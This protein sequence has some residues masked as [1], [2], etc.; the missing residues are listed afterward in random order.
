MARLVGEQS[1]PRDGIKVFASQLHTHL[2][3][4]RIYTKHYRNG[5]EL[6]ELN[7]DNHFSPHYQEIR[8]LARPVHVLPVSSAHLRTCLSQS[9]HLCRDYH[10][11][12]TS[13]RR[14][15]DCSTS[16]AG[17]PT[18]APAPCKLTFDL[19]TLKVVSESRVAWSTS[20]PILVFIGLS[21]LDLGPMY[22]I[23]RHQTHIIA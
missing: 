2:T 10:Y 5:V 7:R 9:R 4:R 22:A 13:V 23:D 8:K 19:L 3:G 17:G 18:N 21:V 20:V 11:D 6:P 16:C 14:A 15:F 12:S 1:L